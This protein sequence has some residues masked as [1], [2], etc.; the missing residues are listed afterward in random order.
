MGRW[1]LILRNAVAVAAFFVVAAIAIAQQKIVTER[2]SGM[3][4]C[5]DCSGI[6]TILLLYRSGQG[7]LINYTMRETFVGKP[8]AGKPRV[9]G[10]SWTILHGS[11]ADKNAIVYQLHQAGST[12]VINFVKA[13]DELRMLG[14]DMTELPAGVPHTLKLLI[15]DRVVF[16][17]DDRTG[18]NVSLKVGGELE[19]Q[20]PA[21]HTTGYGW[22]PVPVE[23]PLLISQGKASYVENTAG[24]KVGAG[25]V[26]T[27]LFKAVKGGTEDLKFE[28]RR[29]WEKGVPAAKTV[30]IQ[31]TVQ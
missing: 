18:G 11:A 13:D 23:N 7:D 2:Y 25:G 15:A 14:G 26:E 31:V 3:L 5:A 20:L 8:P 28:Y 21:N 30:T 6:E 10:G 4:P 19:V 24:G 27:W 22:T 1:G 16:K 9:T 12:A 29:P 17:T